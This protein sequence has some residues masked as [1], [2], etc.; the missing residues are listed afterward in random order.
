MSDKEKDL[1]MGLTP[2]SPML[3]SRFDKIVEENNMKPVATIYASEDGNFVL[4]IRDLS[5]PQRILMILDKAFPAA[6]KEK[7][8]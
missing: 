7:F 6:K 8:T 2:R 1:M 3:K 5:C 4:C